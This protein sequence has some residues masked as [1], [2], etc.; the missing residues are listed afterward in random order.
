MKS[1]ADAGLFFQRGASVQ[2]AMCEL[3]TACRIGLRGEKPLS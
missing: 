2:V 3:Q 1:P